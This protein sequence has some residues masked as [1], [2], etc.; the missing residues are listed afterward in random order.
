MARRV[1]F[2]ERDLRVAVRAVKAAGV[3]VG[4]IEIRG[5]ILVIV[6][7]GPC[8]ADPGKP[9]PDTDPE[10]EAALEAVRRAKI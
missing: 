2:R 6:P 1:S 7:G 4:R 10:T 3:P 9:D 8:T 5:N